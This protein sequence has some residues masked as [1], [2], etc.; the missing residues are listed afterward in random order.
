MPRLNLFNRPALILGLTVALLWSGCQMPTGGVSTARI[1]EYQERMTSEEPFQPAPEL[2]NMDRP[3]PVELSGPAAATQPAIDTTIWLHVP[4]PEKAEE[5][6]AKRLEITRF[7]DSVRR[8]YE[9]IYKNALKYIR[10]IE[11]PNKFRLSLSDAIRRALANNYAIKVDGY[12]PAISAAQVVQ[13]ESAFD[14]AFFANVSRDNSDRPTPSAILASQTDTTIINGGIRKLLATG[15]QLSFTQQMTRVDNPGFQFQVLNPSYTQNFVAELRQPLLRN[16][17]IDF[18][19]AQINIRKNERRINEEAF[20][21]RVIET[22]NN[23]EAAYWTLI[24]AR[25]DVPISAELLA[26]AELTYEQVKA[27]ADFDAYQTLLF[28]SEAAVKAREFD[29]IDVKNRVRNAEDQLLNL[30]ND[31]EIP[32]STDY[33]IIPTDDPTTIRVLQDRFHAVETG[34]EHRPEIRQAR[35]AVD[36]TRLQLGIAKN[37]AL[38]QLDAIYRMTLTGLAASPDRSFDQMTGANFVDQFVGIEILWNPGERGERAGIRIAKLQQSQAVLQYKQALDNIIT[39][40]RVA[41][42]NLDTNYEQLGPS[43]EAVT[44]TSENLRSLQ[45]RQERKSPAELDVILNAQVS[46][47]QSR[48]GLLTALVNYNSGIVDVERAKGTLIE[49]NNVTVAEEP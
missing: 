28:Q 48:R 20:R 33:E 26:E 2:T 6:Y 10:Q 11:R 19:R 41:L 30:L 42:R 3:A 44:S 16:F 17:G 47:A 1:D 13:A 8:E 7:S 46:L 24:G 4:D 49:Y 25:R 15:A 18:N 39:D 21:A 14:L 22:L 36:N 32:L 40:I 45:E 38:P 29:F 9:E 43:H 31:P 12:A 27:R 34:L 37:Q 23:V 5:A 35:L